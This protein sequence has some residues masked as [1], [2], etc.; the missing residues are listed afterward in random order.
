MSYGGQVTD[1]R[2]ATLIMSLL[3]KR[4]PS[5]RIVREEGHEQ[6]RGGGE[7]SPIILHNATRLTLHLLYRCPN[8]KVPFCPPPCSPLSAPPHCGPL[9]PSWDTPLSHDI[10]PPPNPLSSALH[11]SP[12]LTLFFTHSWNF[13]F[14]VSIIL[15]IRMVPKF[16]LFS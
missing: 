8:P 14:M 7:A 3:K 13:T 6:N 11:P 16:M 15:S 5:A 2:R 4:P 1:G 12:I 10:A 9:L